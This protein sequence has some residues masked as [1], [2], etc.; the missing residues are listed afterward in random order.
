MTGNKVILCY[1][2]AG[3]V[4]HYLYDQKL[5]RKFYDAFKAGYKEDPTGREALEETVGKPLE[6]FE[7]DWKAWMLKRVAPSMR[8]TPDSPYLG[9]QFG[10]ANDGMLVQTVVKNGPAAKAGLRVGDVI[11]A[12]GNVEARDEMSFMPMIAAH[13]PGDT[14]V[15]R[16]RRDH[17]YLEVPMI[18]GRRNDPNSGGAVPVELP[19]S[20]PSTSKARAPSSRPS[21]QPAAATRP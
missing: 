1:A 4:M 6:E 12:I 14:V 2:E 15:F 20:T 19:R 13:K 16:L 5:L 21:T 3:S 7:K 9:V 10:P 17:K 8:M 11:I 18:L